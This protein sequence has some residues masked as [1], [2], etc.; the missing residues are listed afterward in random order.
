M[1]EEKP[2]MVMHELYQFSFGLV[3]GVSGVCV[4]YPIGKQNIRKPPYF[5]IFARFCQN[6]S[7]KSAFNGSRQHG[8]TT[9]DI[10]WV[11][12]LISK[13]GVASRNSWSL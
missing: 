1:S 2:R 3:A 11:S 5:C 9:H 6:E 10:S 13:S 4:V 8:Q 7:A 12:R